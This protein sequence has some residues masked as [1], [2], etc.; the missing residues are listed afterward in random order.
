[1][2]S[3]DGISH[4]SNI[5]L[6][7][8]YNK[9]RSFNSLNVLAINPSLLVEYY[10]IDYSSDGYTWYNSHHTPIF[11]ISDKLVNDM[12]AVA[13]I[14][15]NMRCDAGIYIT[16][17]SIA[18]KAYLS[19]ISNAKVVSALGRR[20]KIISDEMQKMCDSID[21]IEKMKFDG[22][23][24]IISSMLLRTKDLK[25]E[26]NSIGEKAK[27]IRNKINISFKMPILGKD[28]IVLP[29]GKR[30]LREE[31]EGNYDYGI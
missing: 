21:Y 25:E 20:I 30:V 31:I 24:T 5:M 22:S 2:K 16:M 6:C 28:H 26:I 23:S 1:M 14:E 15:G 19:D 3:I 27:L 7:P 9:G 10:E 11:T 12:L 4:I 17:S 13:Y 8:Y 18:R 29:N